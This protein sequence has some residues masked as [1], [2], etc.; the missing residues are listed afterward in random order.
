MQEF[1]YAVGRAGAVAIFVW[2]GFGK[3]VA[4]DGTALSIASKGLPVPQVLAV[5][6]ALVE[7][8]AGIMVAVGFKTRWAALALIAFAAAATYLFHDFWNMTGS[9]RTQNLIQFY[10]N[11]SVVGALLMIVATGG[12]RF[13]VDRG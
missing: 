5:S 10:K 6:A 13:S 3:L 1:L 4:I 7:I 11:L 2:S 9:A 12:G 8:V